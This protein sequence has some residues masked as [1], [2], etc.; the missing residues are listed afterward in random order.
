L[1]INVNICIVLQIF[2]CLLQEILLF[3]AL[4]KT[5]NQYKNNL[6]LNQFDQYIIPFY[7]LFEIK[8]KIFGSIFP[9]R[10]L[11]MTKLLSLFVLLAT[12]ILLEALRIFKRS[13]SGGFFFEGW[14]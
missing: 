3:C 13:F 6:F 10:K 1:K 14:L 2:I 8:N 7:L 4:N 11:N 9:L 5:K 12:Q